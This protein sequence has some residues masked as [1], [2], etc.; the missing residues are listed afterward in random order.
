MCI[1]PVTG[2]EK[3][4]KMKLVRV[5]V[6]LAKDVIQVYDVDQKDKPLWSRRL[7]RNNWLKV[8]LETVETGCEFVMKASS[9]A[10]D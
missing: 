8:L 6:E 7:S 4:S 10:R 9:G 1:P 5:G 3:E 2:E